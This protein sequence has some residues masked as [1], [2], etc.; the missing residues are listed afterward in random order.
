MKQKKVNE[1]NDKIVD[2]STFA[3][4]IKRRYKQYPVVLEEDDMYLSLTD[5]IGQH[6]VN[7]LHF[8]KVSSSFGFLYLV[9]IEKFGFKINK[10]QLSFHKNSL[11]SRW[12]QLD[13]IVTFMNIFEPSNEDILLKEIETLKST[14]DLHNSPHFHHIMSQLHLLLTPKKGRRYDKETFVLAAELFN[15]SPL[16]CQVYV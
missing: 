2:F 5:R 8:R 6:V 1:A 9:N 11:L 7:F 13:E 14:S 4:E 12:S 16:L 15:I 10:S 3:I